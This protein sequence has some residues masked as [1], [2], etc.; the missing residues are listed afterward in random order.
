MINMNESVK[1]PKNKY[2]KWAIFK[3][4]MFDNDHNPVNSKKMALENISDGTEII[5]IKVFD[6]NSSVML[7][8]L[9]I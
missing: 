6:L 7:S 3:L 4:K 9:Y 5:D 8:V 1:I 2:I